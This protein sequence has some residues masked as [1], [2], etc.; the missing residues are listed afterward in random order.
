MSNLADS[1]RYLRNTTIPYDVR[2]RCKLRVSFTG[3]IM[4]QRSIEEYGKVTRLMNDFLFLDYLYTHRTATEVF[5]TA[6]QNRDVHIGGG[7]AGAL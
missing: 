2:A 6:A 3:S 7:A 1:R 5:V 4:E